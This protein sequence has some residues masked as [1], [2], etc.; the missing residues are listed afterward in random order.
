MEPTLLSTHASTPTKPEPP[1]PSFN[2]SVPQPVSTRGLQHHRPLQSTSLKSSS[3]N[4]PTS[5]FPSV[6]ASGP[7]HQGQQLHPHSESP[8]NFHS[9]SYQNLNHPLSPSTRNPPYLGG[10]LQD[11][12]RP[13]ACESCRSLKVR[14]EPND[15]TAS[16]SD[17][18]RRCAKANRLC[19]F[20]LPTRKRQKKADS[21]VAE[22]E[23]KIDA[24]T[25]TLNA[26][27][28][29]K[30][31]QIEGDDDGVEETDEHT[32]TSSHRLPSPASVDQHGYKRRRSITECIQ[33]AG[34]GETG[35]GGGGD[36][37]GEDCDSEKQSHRDSRGGLAAATPVKVH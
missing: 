33:G 15:P 5:P 9:P 16:S 11:H 20:T 35:A 19:I 12:K 32:S 30:A 14:C 7:Q 24:L 22:L 1:S 13:R 4:S 25:A 31:P 27:R 8:D 29:V 28:Q 26:S 17:T 23:R 36:G 6:Y 2:S 18:C 37:Y 10:S 34:V 3:Q 21:K